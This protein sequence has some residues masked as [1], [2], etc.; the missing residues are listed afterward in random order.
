[1]WCKRTNVVPDQHP[2]YRHC[3]SIKTEERMQAL[4]QGGI[5]VFGLFCVACIINWW[6]PHVTSLF[7]RR[8][9]SYFNHVC[10]VLRAYLSNCFPLFKLE[11]KKIDSLHRLIILSCA[12]I[13]SVWLFFFTVG[14]D[15]ANSKSL[16]RQK[17]RNKAVKGKS[18]IGTLLFFKYGLN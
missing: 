17:K 10:P 4:S 2:I 16:D 9:T 15:S 5:E 8:L 13:F 11:K 6:K 18:W 1:M 14:F 12:I 7:V 3:I